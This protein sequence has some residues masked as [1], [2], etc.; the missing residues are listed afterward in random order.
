[1]ITNLFDIVLLGDIKKIVTK[2]NYGYADGFLERLKKLAEWFVP[3]Q[4][5]LDENPELHPGAYIHY[6]Q[7]EDMQMFEGEFL[8]HFT[9]PVTDLRKYTNGTSIVKLSEQVSN[10]F[11]NI[12]T[13]I[14]DWHLEDKDIFFLL[15]TDAIDGFRYDIT[16]G[17]PL[18][19]G[20]ESIKT[21]G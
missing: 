7:S 17:I 9:E 1:M 8:P 13:V 15:E 6:L 21:D 11:F 12:C 5:E 14:R 2:K 3:S 16:L 18:Y 4:K 10:I 19:L 20:K